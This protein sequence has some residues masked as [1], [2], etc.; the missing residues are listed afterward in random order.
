[1]CVCVCVCVVAQVVDRAT[2]AQIWMGNITMWNDSRIQ[3]LNTA[4]AHK[5]PAA[6]IIIGYLEGAEDVSVIAVF[7]AALC[8]F[9][10]EFQMALAAAH[11]TFA[12]MVPAQRGMAI[13]VGVTAASRIDFL[14]VLPHSSPI[15]GALL[16]LTPLVPVCCVGSVLYDHKCIRRTTTA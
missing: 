6:P 10:A 13:P 12:N 15:L 4:I 14:T 1:V 5:L 7:K 2:L 11:N 9:S 16:V 3:A 8:S